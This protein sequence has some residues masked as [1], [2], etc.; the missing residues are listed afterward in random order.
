[1]SLKDKEWFD[2]DDDEAALE[3]CN[4]IHEKPEEHS[5]SNDYSDYTLVSEIYEKPT[6]EEKEKLI[7]SIIEFDRLSYI[8]QRKTGRRPRYQTF[9]YQSR[10]LYESDNKTL[11]KIIRNIVNQILDVI[12]QHG[13]R[14]SD[15]PHIY[16]KY[17]PKNLIRFPY[18]NCPVLKYIHRHLIPYRILSR[19]GILPWKRTIELDLPDDEYLHFL[20]HNMEFLSEIEMIEIQ[21]H[22]EKGKVKQLDLIKWVKEDLQQRFDVS[23]ELRKQTED[24]IIR[25]ELSHRT[26]KQRKQLQEIYRKYDEVMTERRKEYEKQQQQLIDDGLRRKRE[27]EELKQGKSIKRREEL[28]ISSAAAICRLLSTESRRKKKR[29]K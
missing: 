29:I 9:D 18:E 27:L 15:R 25:F 14:P 13:Y 6:D 24:E 26:E 1:M 10:N 23:P 16:T 19:I 20:L 5:I 7:D 11:K 3:Y 8:L 17:Y 28:G 2:M 21:S 12:W 22:L 4:W